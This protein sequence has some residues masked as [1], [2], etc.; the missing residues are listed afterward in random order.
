ML[1]LLLAVVA[2]QDPAAV[3]AESLL[4]AGRVHFARPVVGRYAAL[5]AFRAAARLVPADPEPLYWQMKVG[6]YLGSDEG[7]VL[8]RESILRIL[9]LRPDYEDVWERFQTLYRNP[10][11]W[12]RADHVLARHR[13]DVIAM[14]RRAQVAIALERPLVADSLLDE[15]L[16]RKGAPDVPAYLL[17]AEANF[18]AQRDSAGYAWYDS[19]LAYADVDSSG[20]MWDAVWM[21]AS[22]AEIAAQDSLEPG[23]RG[24]FFARFWAKR[25]PN[26][27]TPGNERIAEHFR[28]FAYARRYFRLLHP[29]NLYQRSPRYRAVIAAT[30]RDFLKARGQSQ[31][32]PYPGAETDRILAASRQLPD[33]AAGGATASALAGL[34]ARGLIYIRHGRP[35][36]LLRGY[37]DPLNPLGPPEKPLDV[38][39][40]LYRTPQGILSIG[41]RRASGSTDAWLAGGDFIFLPTNRRQAR[42]T[43]VALQTD[44]STLPAPLDAHGWSAFFQSGDPGL[45]DVYFKAPGDSAAAVLWDAHDEPLRAR[46]PGDGLLELSVPPGRYDLGLDVDSSGV[47]GRTRREILVARFSRVELR[48]SSL[49][50]APGPSLLDRDAALRGMPADLAYPAG[51]PLSTYVEVYGLTA[52]QGGRSQYRVRYTFAPVQSAVGRLFGGARPVVFEFDREIRG[53]SALERLV[54]TPDELP[55][56]RY[57]VTVGVTDLRRNVKSESTALEVIIR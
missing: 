47:L 42:S 56:G 45:T 57:R 27:V 12:R 9:A 44:R 32:D 53:G 13:D 18:D 17:R 30:Q 51:S 1:A 29:L 26:L 55:P 39:G 36:Q 49:V 3:R 14:E 35:D 38:E 5:E 8:A 15:V 4:A 43:R 7:D 24:R 54:I 2:L 11:I 34:D 33:V 20:A 21:I 41:F 37:F 46:G 6:F 52:D 16:R 25:D 40:W 19:A 23:E 10:G 31:V 28:R 48:L 22:P 50:L